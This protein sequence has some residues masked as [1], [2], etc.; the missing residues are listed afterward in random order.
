MLTP[1]D[2]QRLDELPMEKL[3]PEFLSQSIHLREL[4]F[5]KSKPKRMNNRE[6]NGAVLAGLA[7]EYVRAINGGAVPNIESAW[8]YVCSAQRE[9]LRLELTNAFEDELEEELQVRLPLE[10]AQIQGLIK[11]K[12]RGI[13]D[14]FKKESLDGLDQDE[15][16]RLKEALKATAERV[17]ERNQSAL[18][19]LVRSALTEGYREQVEQPLEQ[20]T[21]D[22]ARMKTEEMEQNQNLSRGLLQDE[23]SFEWVERE[24]QSFGLLSK[25][26][27]GFADHMSTGLVPFTPLKQQMLFDF[28]T[29][30]LLERGGECYQDLAKTVKLALLAKDSKLGLLREKA[31]GCEEV[32]AKVKKTSR[33]QIG[34]LED[35]VECLGRERDGLERRMEMQARELRKELREKEAV[36]EEELKGVREKRGL[37]EEKERGEREQLREQVEGLRKAVNEEETKAMLLEQK[38][39]FLEKEKREWDQ[40]R[41]QMGTQ[42]EEM[43]SQ[44]E[45]DKEQ[46]RKELEAHVRSLRKEHKKTK[47]QFREYKEE[48]TH[49]SILQ[50]SMCRQMGTKEEELMQ[51]LEAARRE[52][53]EARRAE[54]DARERAREAEKEA[55]KVREDMRREK[56]KKGEES[57]SVK[58]LRKQLEARC[59]EHEKNEALWEQEMR[60]VEEEKTGLREQ[61]NDLRRVH[62]KVLV[63]IKLEREGDK[64]RKQSQVREGLRK[65]LEQ[66]IREAEQAKHEVETQL[67][68]EIKELQRR[69]EER[70]AEMDKMRE[71]RQQ[72]QDELA[73]ESARKERL[74]E[75]VATM[76][77]QQKSI[78][79]DTEDLWKSKVARAEAETEAEKRRTAEAVRSEREV[80]EGRMQE[81]RDFFE[82]KHKAVEEKLKLEREAGERRRKEL[83]E[84]WVDK[85]ENRTRELEEEK[86]ELEEELGE[87]EGLGQYWKERAERLEKDSQDKLEQERQDKEKIGGKLRA[88]LGVEMQKAE[89]LREELRKE[90][91]DGK[92]QFDALKK[93]LLAKN[94]ELGELRQ[95]LDLALEKG[96]RERVER[97][98][99][100][101]K[102]REETETVEKRY[103]QAKM[104]KVRLAE[105]L[106]QMRVEFGKQTALGQQKVE[107]KDKRI[108]ELT[109]RN[110]GLSQKLQS[111]VKRVK[112]ALRAKMDQMTEAHREE[113]AQLEGRFEEKRLR[114]KDVEVETQNKL[115]GLEKEKTMLAERVKG[116]EEKLTEEASA[117]AK[118][119]ERVEREIAKVR[120]AARAEK[121]AL[122]EELE[123]QREKAYEAEIALTSVQ[124]RLEKEEALLKNKLKFLGQQRDQLKMDL[125]ES[126]KNFD[127]M[128]NKL[129]QYRAEENSER[130][131]SL[132]RQV[133]EM[134]HAHQRELVE[135]RKKHQAREESCL[136]RVAELEAEVA[137]LER[138]NQLTTS[139][140]FGSRLSEEKKLNELLEKEKLLQDEMMVLKCEKNSIRLYY[141]RD[142]ERAREEWKVKLFEFECELKKAENERNLLVFEHEKQRTKWMIE[143]DNWL[144]QKHE[145]V[146]LVE[147]LQRQKEHLT[148]ENER[149]K[150]NIKVL[151]KSNVG[152]LQ[153]NLAKSRY[154]PTPKKK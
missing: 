134:S 5:S 113:L 101:R 18:E 10:E 87:M 45:S 41:K 54:Q 95:R 114:L 22:K 34:E 130:E 123:K 126:Q 19:D 103:S 35:T 142:M 24:A 122:E 81:M 104:E 55:S 86:Q 98:N 93:E 50:E 139:K 85:F 131:E 60:F 73:A 145:N 151:K 2:L 56:E 117:R 74:A 14:K 106:I 63:A 94:A 118:Q 108:G 137:R 144:F 96:Q 31:K 150:A 110:E 21:R 97:D 120:E 33:A 124:V 90:K 107:F 100:E 20:F 152:H 66:R 112:D 16:S 141:Q 61:L 125:S 57:K 77:A 17:L 79:K 88:L 75:Q 59:K 28:V 29:K 149:L 105:E 128:V 12:K 53:K 133:E 8:T 62:E 64:G 27:R 70:G 102:L 67:K 140:Q 109:K 37:E 44:F 89:G 132:A 71:E 42:M 136:A 51:Q 78:V 9:K 46:L 25:L 127:V 72:T 80:L 138:L 115:L 40:E 3:R 47:E 39:E 99:R 52:S 135:Q 148:K 119:T 146:G 13:K 65:E 76:E 49:Q 111:E 32:L 121:A 92:G 58:D 82:E 23:E 91:E 84:E 4:L 83:E 154:M 43:E 48:V 68:E 11:E 116:L 38:V 36:F 15:L 6:I 7:Q 143:R 147:K 30:K 129:Q 69:A 26:I 1:D 153:L